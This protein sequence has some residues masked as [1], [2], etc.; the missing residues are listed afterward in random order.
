M[1]SRCTASAGGSAGPTRR[2]CAL[3]C[4]PWTTKRD[5]I[6]GQTRQDKMSGLILD[7]GQQSL[8]ASEMPM[9]KDAYKRMEEWPRGVPAGAWGPGGTRPGASQG[10]PQGLEAG[11]LWLMFW[12]HPFRNQARAWAAAKSIQQGQRNFETGS[13]TRWTLMQPRTTVA[14]RP[15]GVARR[16]NLQHGLLFCT[17]GLMC[18][19]ICKCICIGIN[20]Y[21]LPTPAAGGQVARQWV[22]LGS[23]VQRH[24][25]A[26]HGSL[27]SGLLGQ[28]GRGQAGLGL[29]GCPVGF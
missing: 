24:L 28:V 9:I 27:S 26:T 13:R 11:S 15:A 20:S 21:C 5:C 22:L 6:T 29:E 7:K 10:T 4:L 2:A 23:L 19:C 8:P 14:A 3:V 18:K 16:S 12:C 25:A 17:H 1:L